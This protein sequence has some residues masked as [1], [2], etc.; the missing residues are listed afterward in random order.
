MKRIAITQRV[1]VDG[2]H[3]ERRDALDQRWYAFLQACELVPVLIPN[4]VDSARALISEVPVSGVLFTGGNDLVSM[5]GNAP[6]RDQTENMLLDWAL[7]QALPVLGVCRGMQLIQSKFGVGLE[8]VT[9]HVANVQEIVIEGE[10]NIVNSYHHYG[11]YKTSPALAIFAQASDGVVKGIRHQSYPVTAIMWH[12]ERL[13]P[14]SQRDIALF[15]TV[16]AQGGS[17]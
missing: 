7:D 17:K 5:G 11:A 13:T 14:F 10:K 2:A 6:E 3:Q 4:H 15:Q 12:P 1:I 8:T 16:F 9:G